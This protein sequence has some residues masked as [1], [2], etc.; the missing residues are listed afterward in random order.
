MAEII[1]LDNNATTPMAPEALEAMLPFFR[2][3]CGNP[4]SAHVQGLV[5]EGALVNAREQVA[6]L[7]GCQPAEVV[8]NGGGTEGLNHAFRGIFETLPAKR[9]FVTTA[10]EHSAV[11]ALVE[12]LKRNGA[13]VTV[14]P[15][16]AAGRLDLGQLEAAIRPDTA[17]VSVMAANNETG[18][19]FPL[20]EI[21]ALVKGRGALFHVDATQ[22]AGKLPLDLAGLPVDLLNLSAHKFHGPKGVGALFIRRGLRLR[23]FLVGGHQERGRRGGTENL[24]GIVGLGKA[25]A[26]AREHLGAMVR[27]QRLRDE[28]EASLKVALPELGIHGEG[29]PRLPNTSFLGFPGV[30]G[31]A[32]LLRLSQ[33]GICVSTGS[34]CTTGQKEPSHVLRAMGVRSELAQGTIRLSLSRY[35]TEAEITRVAAL[36]PELVQALRDAGPLA[37]R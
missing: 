25:A 24:P 9:H 5:A 10:V 37:R 17:L 29:A 36:I 20:A 30:E 34:A 8:F 35:T 1:Y 13:E 2:E 4:S 18:V 16:D 3:H 11:L 26:L 32:L 33:N 21:A 7:L 22:A 23:P 27:V 28:L 31:E 19:C 15:V 6:A 12:W 14:L